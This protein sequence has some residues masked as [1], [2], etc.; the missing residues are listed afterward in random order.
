MFQ[1][2]LQ[3]EIEQEIEQMKTQ[4]WSIKKKFF[5]PNQGCADKNTQ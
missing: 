5:K 3:Q 2:E 4:G 1:E